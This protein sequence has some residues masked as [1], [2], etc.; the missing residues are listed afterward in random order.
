[1]MSKDSV[2]NRLETGLSFTE[3]SYQLLQAYDFQVLYE[4]YDCELQ[5][6]GSDQWGNITSGSE[7]IRRNA[8][9]KAFALTTPLLT[10]SDGKKF[11]KSEKGNIWLDPEMT[12]PYQFYQFWINSD[13][14]DLPNYFR[15]FSF[16]NQEEIKSLEKEYA[17]DPRTLKKILADEITTTVHSEG[18]C[19]SAKAVSNLLFNKHASRESLLDMTADTLAQVQKEL[20]TKEISSDALNNGIAILDLLTENTGILNSKGEARR[21]IQNNAISINKEKISDLELQVKGHQLLHGRYLMVEN[22]KKNKYMIVVN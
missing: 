8:G 15:T 4:K 19:N 13:D 3:F 11:G 2:K 17:D 9:G 18:A 20:E 14:A 10:K 1:M 7:F 21:A 5:M 16:K 12:S 22:G 6:G